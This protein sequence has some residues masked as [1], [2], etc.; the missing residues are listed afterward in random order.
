MN[1]KKKRA[2]NG[3]PINLFVETVLVADRTIYDDHQRFAKITDPDLTFQFMK[4]Y[5]SHFFSGVNQHYVNSLT[6][7]A[8]LRISIKLKNFIF[9]TVDLTILK[10]FVLNF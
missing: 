1:Q 6:D 8:D 7:D 2:V 10:Y 3:Q 4:I 5:Y 9:F